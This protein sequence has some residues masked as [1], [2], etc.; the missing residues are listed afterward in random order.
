MLR[1]MQVCR[2]CEMW[3]R[4]SDDNKVVL[5]RKRPKDDISD[6][7]YS[8]KQFRSPRGRRARLTGRRAPSIRSFPRVAYRVIAT[9]AMVI[10]LALALWGWNRV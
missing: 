10:L 7:Y 3:R 4:N 9:V 5:L 1:S 2:V 8:P 6:A